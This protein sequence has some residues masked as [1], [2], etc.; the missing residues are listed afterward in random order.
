MLKIGLPV[1]VPQVTFTGSRRKAT[2]DFCQRPCFP[3]KR[4]V[5]RPRVRG[6]RIL[7]FFLMEKKRILVFF[8]LLLVLGSSLTV[9]N[10]GLPSKMAEWYSR[11]EIGLLKKISFSHEKEIRPLDYY[12]GKIEDAWVGPLTSVISGGL[13]LLFC[14]WFMQGAGGFAAQDWLIATAK[15]YA[16][17]TNQTR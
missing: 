15:E 2:R 12:T 7:K 14:L 6:K 1:N 4:V 3:T 10:M 11:G 17:S 8:C 5:F 16:A 9:L 13:F